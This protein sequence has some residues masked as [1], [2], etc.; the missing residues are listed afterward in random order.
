[1]SII[2]EFYMAQDGR[3]RAAI[4]QSVEAIVKTKEILSQ[5]GNAQLAVELMLRACS[6]I[7]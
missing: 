3:S 7:K 6:G 5:N 2:E 4:D 1:M